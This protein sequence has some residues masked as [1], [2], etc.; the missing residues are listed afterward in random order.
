M[1]K[2]K[3]VVLIILGALTTKA[4]TVWNGPNITFTKAPFA[5]PTQVGNYDS[6]TTLTKIVRDNTKGIYNLVSETGYDNTLFTSPANTEWANGNIVNYSTLTYDTWDVSNGANPP[7]NV[8]VAK[9]MHLIAEDIYIPVTFTSWS[10]GSAAGGGFSWTR[11]TAP[12]ISLNLTH[13]EIKYENSKVFFNW[14]VTQ[15]ESYDYFTIESS[16]NSI[17]WNGIATLEAKQDL[18]EYNYSFIPENPS[19]FVYYRIVLHSKN[20]EI[21]YSAT[22]SVLYSH[23]STSD[24]SFYPNPVSTNGAL[25]INYKG[26]ENESFLN[27]ININGQ[28]I[29]QLRI[30]KNEVQSIDT[31]NLS[32]GIYFIHLPNSNKMSKFQVN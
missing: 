28:L 26:L 18:S 15:A 20:G 30:S 29:K 12:S 5:V 13:C 23:Q 10:Q 11:G 2:I 25:L 31:R 16:M 1:K 17:K 14:S 7:A 24:I 9:V 3:L 8:G 21:Q 22:K 27:I 6:L 19:G 32:S 4:Q